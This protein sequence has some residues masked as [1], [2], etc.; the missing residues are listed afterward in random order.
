MTTLRWRSGA[1]PVSQVQDFVFAGTWES[2][3]VITVAIGNKTLS[4]TATSATTATV[5]SALVTTF[6]AARDNADGFYP[7]FADLTASAPGSSTTFRITAATEGLPFTCTIATTETGGGAADAQTIDGAASSTGTAST[8][9]SGPNHW[10]TA[11]NWSTGAVPV[12]ADDVII[13]DTDAAILYGLDQSAVTLTSLTINA[14]YSGTIGLPEVNEDEDEAYPEYRSTY[15]TIGATTLTIGRGDGQG[16]GRLKISNSNIQ[17]ALDVQSTGSGL[18]ANLPALLWKGTNASN[19]VNITSGSMG[20]AHVAGETATVTTL[21]ASGDAVVIAGSGT[22]LTT[23]NQA[24][25]DV[26]LYA[27][28]TTVTKT[29]GTLTLWAGNVTTIT[30]D[31]GV[32]RY[33]GTGTVTTWNVGSGAVAAF[34]P[35]DV[36]RGTLAGCTITNC[37]LYAGAALLDP[38][39]RVTFSNGFRLTRDRWADFTIDIGLHRLIT[40]S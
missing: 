36:P 23:L 35:A 22:T 11:A 5:V 24:G 7:E 10:N 19:V 39:G 15:L 26:T 16:S 25:G 20:I 32:T 33:L 1:V 12:A 8:A 18:D 21:R 40:P 3:D 6:N 13:A 30:D 27:G 38:W 4:T 31:E 2:T 34:T 29:G 28:L 17:T 9:C 14:S 37:T